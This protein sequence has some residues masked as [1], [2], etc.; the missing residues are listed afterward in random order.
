LHFFTNCDFSIRNK[1]IILQRGIPFKLK[2]PANQPVDVSTLT[3]T[4]MNAELEKGYPDMLEGRT[5]PTKQAFADIRKD[6]NVCKKHPSNL[7]ICFV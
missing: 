2:V 1:Q 6:Y 5:Q 3:D 4:Q 7:P